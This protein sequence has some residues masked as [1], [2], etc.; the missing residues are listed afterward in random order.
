[1]S[2]THARKPIRR[3]FLHRVLPPFGWRLYRALGRS[4]T[5]HSPDAAILHRLIEAKQP[6]VGAFLHARTF[7]LLHYFSLTEQ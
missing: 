6:V 5:Y 4:W 3:F 1:M 2:G 7:A